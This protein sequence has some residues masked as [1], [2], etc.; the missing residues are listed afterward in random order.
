[1]TKPSRR[2]IWRLLARVLAIVVVG[3]AL[4]VSASAQFFEDRPGL[5]PAPLA[6]FIA[7]PWTPLVAWSN[8]SELDWAVCA[9]TVRQF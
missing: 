1:M 4:A 2:H 3:S 7:V 8:L 5:P 6:V 9:A